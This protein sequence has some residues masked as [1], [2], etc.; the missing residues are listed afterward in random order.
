MSSMIINGKFNLFAASIAPSLGSGVIKHAMF[1]L[2]AI[3]T[4]TESIH[5]LT[6]TSPVCA[7]CKKVNFPENPSIEK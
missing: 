7:S 3:S 2:N 1:L 5:S 6:T 4:P